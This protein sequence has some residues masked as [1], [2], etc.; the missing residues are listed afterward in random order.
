MAHAAFSRAILIAAA[1]GAFAPARAQ[2]ESVPS[3]A[4]AADTAPVQPRSALDLPIEQIAGLPDGCAILDRDFPGLREHPMYD[5]FKTMT[6][7]Q[8]AALSKGEIT[9]EMLAR[10]QTDLATASPVSEAAATPVTGRIWA[11]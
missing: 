10:A 6:L 8:V 1:I 11:Q 3:R 9:P 5:F 2:S 4:A 7:N